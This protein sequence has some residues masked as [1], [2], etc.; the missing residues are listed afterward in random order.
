MTQYNI[1]EKW[2]ENTSKNNKWWLWANCIR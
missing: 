1:K 2:N